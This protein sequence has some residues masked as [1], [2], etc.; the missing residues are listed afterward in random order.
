MGA[1]K[2]KMPVKIAYK[3]I[4]GFDV[5]NG[6]VYYWLLVNDHKQPEAVLPGNQSIS[7]ETN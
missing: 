6:F 2:T 7:V 1:K 4:T 5:Y 3:F